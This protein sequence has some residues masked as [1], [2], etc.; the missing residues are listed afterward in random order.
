MCVYVREKKS[1]SLYV[2]GWEVLIKNVVSRNEFVYFYFLHQKRMESHVCP[3]PQGSEGEGKC[4]IRRRR[5]REG[6]KEREG[7]LG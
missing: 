5:R 4:V 6:R 2:S 3:R 1:V 7:T